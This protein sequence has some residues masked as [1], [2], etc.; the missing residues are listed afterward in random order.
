[1]SRRIQESSVYAIT[2]IALLPLESCQII[3]AFLISL[4]CKEIRI[5]WSAGFVVERPWEDPG[6]IGT[7]ELIFK[8]RTHLD[9]QVRMF[10]QGTLDLVRILS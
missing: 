9:I 3:I 8:L 10:L 7:D 1:M 2:T 5:V 4:W 6:E